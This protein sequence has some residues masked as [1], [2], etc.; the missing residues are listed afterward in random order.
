MVKAIIFDCFGVLIEDALSVMR[1]GLELEKK[2]EVVTLMHASHR[3]L[4][5]PEDSD[6]QVAALFGMDMRQ[7]HMAIRDG[8]VKNRLLLDY[9]S[10]LRESYKTAMLSNVSIGGITRRFTAEELSCFDT[11]VASGEIGY[12]K[13]EPEAY[14]IAAD[15]LGVRLDECVFTDD[16]AEYCEG[17]RGVG[18]Q[19]ILYTNFIQF[20]T[21]LERL[22]AQK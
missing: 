13:P 22:L 5:S 2:N 4:I 11:V 10:S 15:R 18:M 21:D 7:Y 12:A 6:Q 3:G 19:A 1:Q 20:K 8:E 14:E 17:A 9:V 16:H